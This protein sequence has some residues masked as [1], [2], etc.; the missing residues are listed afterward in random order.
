MI[1]SYRTKGT[2]SSEIEVEIK[3]ENGVKILERAEFTGGCGGNT[4]G[5]SSLVAGMEAESAIKKLK[6]IL[7][8]RKGTSCPDQLSIAVSRALELMDENNS[9]PDYIKNYEKWVNYQGLD[10]KTKSELA[11]ISSDEDKIKDYFF[12]PLEFGTGGLR[13]IMRPGIN[14]MNIY[15]IK[16]A[17]QAM[18]NLIKSQKLEEKGAVIAF[19]SRNNSEL[20]AK[21]A[22]KTLAANGIKVYIFDDIRPTPELSFAIRY[23]NCAAGINITASH[24]PKEYNGYKA[25]WQDGGQLPPDHAQTISDIISETDIFTGVLTCHYGEMIKQG[26]INIIGEETDKEY[27][28]NVMSQSARPGMITRA[29]KD[30][31]IVYTPIHG[32]GYKLIPEVLAKIGMRP[33][34]L[35]TVPEQMLPDGNFPTVKFPNPEF[36]EVFELGINIAKK[37]NCALIIGTDPDADRMGIAVKTESGEFATITGNQ[38]GALLLDY[39]ITAK[40]E[41]KTLKNSDCVIKTIVTTELA[42]KICEA[43]GVKIIDVLTG[44]K[45]IGEKIKQFESDE[46]NENTFLFGYEESYGYL[47]GTYA[48]DKDAV[49]ASMLIAEMAAYYKIKNMTLFDAMQNLYKKYGYYG[50]AVENIGFAGIDGIEKMKNIMDSLRKTPPLNIGGYKV[51]II[52]DYETSQVK[53]IETGEI[54]DTGL[55]KSDVLYFDLENGSKVIIRPSGTEP[56]IKIYYLISAECEKSAG[57]Q[58]EKLKSAMGKYI[59]V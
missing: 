41:N 49:V 2:C 34:N 24:N 47:A 16:Q 27:L 51:D 18:A 56:K 39:I 17:T 54:S 48:R 43:N 10:S 52:K 46:T 7:C 9:K 28:R 36:K 15:V 6:G 53:N 42:A 29:G 4:Q 5:I 11:N 19:D 38:A 31:K 3:D 25:Y 26:R 30:F 32:A 23:L 22:A 8:G 40:K 57:E 33:E 35:L 55:P 20:F 45:F 21:E 12:A 13:G 1:Y 44:F 14:S 58:A 50:E 59:F 37:N